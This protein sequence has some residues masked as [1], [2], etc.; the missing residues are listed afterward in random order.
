[1]FASD[2]RV[3][4]SGLEDSAD[5]KK[6]ITRQEMG[7]NGR[8]KAEIL[9]YV[10]F[11]TH[12]RKHEND[13]VGDVSCNVIWSCNSNLHKESS[14]FN[15]QLSAIVWELFAHFAASLHTSQHLCWVHS[16]SGLSQSYYCTKDSPSWGC[17]RSRFVDLVLKKWFFFWH[18]GNASDCALIAC[19]RKYGLCKCPTTKKSQKKPSERKVIAL[20]SQGVATEL[21]PG[22]IYQG[23]SL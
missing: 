9:M 1:M 18:S 2:E 4:P 10:F 20:Q 16:V 19:K 22:L 15:C 23:I 7:S 14:E 12:L 5:K 13:V 6:Q 11:K 21:G 3:F 8:P 17:P